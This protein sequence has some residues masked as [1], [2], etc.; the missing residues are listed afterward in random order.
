MSPH[1][2]TSPPRRSMMWRSTNLSPGPQ[3]RV[4]A[5]THTHTHTCARTHTHAH[6][7]TQSSFGPGLHEVIEQFKSI[8]QDFRISHHRS[9]LKSSSVTGGSFPTHGFT[10]SV[11]FCFCFKLRFGFLE[12]KCQCNRITV[13][14][15]LSVFKSSETIRTICLGHSSKCRRRAGH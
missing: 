4:N 5:L 1:Q 12:V 2:L 10:Q 9:M 11:H 15:H 7:H 8:P 14:A 13:R 6:D 3:F